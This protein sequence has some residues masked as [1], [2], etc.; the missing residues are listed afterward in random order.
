MLLLALALRSLLLLAQRSLHHPRRRRLCFISSSQRV[1]TSHFIPSSSTASSTQ[2][3]FNPQ[4][5]YT[6]VIPPMLAGAGNAIRSTRYLNFILMFVPSI[7]FYNPF[8][9]LIKTKHTIVV[10]PKLLL[11]C[12]TFLSHHP[13]R[14]FAFLSRNF[15]SFK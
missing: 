15:Y 6:K 9:N 11:C 8:I 3:Y 2:I 1:Y 4:T 7:N 13:L 12:R 10:L 5:R 14:K